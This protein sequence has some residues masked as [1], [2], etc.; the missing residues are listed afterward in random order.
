M[1]VEKRAPL[2]Q[3]EWIQNEKK[4]EHE[5]DVIRQAKK[6]RTFR[7]SIS[8]PVYINETLTRPTTTP[9]RTTSRPT[10]GLIAGT[11][12]PT[13]K[14]DVGVRYWSLRELN[15]EQPGRISTSAMPIYLV[16]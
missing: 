11:M 6:A 4:D 15:M 1:V 10:S 5:N 8:G 7:A 3:V 9:C 16:T 14:G 13:R 12:T 2:P